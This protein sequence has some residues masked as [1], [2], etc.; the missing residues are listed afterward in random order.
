MKKKAGRGQ[1]T[2]KMGAVPS[3]RDSSG[4]A[5]TAPLRQHRG[6]SSDQPLTQALTV[7]KPLSD[8]TVVPTLFPAPVANVITA[9]ATSA[10]LSLRVVAF[11]IEAILESSQY[12]TR[13]GLGYTRRVLITAISSARRAYLISSEPSVSAMMT[14]P[15]NPTLP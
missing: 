1:G 10:K 9:L 12:T 11:F 7:S 5:V 14:Q 4:H 6:D 15:T 2:M 8:L 3:P 13:L